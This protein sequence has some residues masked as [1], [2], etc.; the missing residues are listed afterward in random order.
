MNSLIIRVFR[1]INKRISMADVDGMQCMR[2]SDTDVL[3]YTL[4]ITSFPSVHITAVMSLFCS[5]SPVCAWYEGLSAHESM[6]TPFCLL[7]SFSS[8]NCI[9]RK[10]TIKG[11]ATCLVSIQWVSIHVAN[12]LG[13]KADR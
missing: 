5:F 12:G 9:R 7:F 2:A 13:S 3:T 11:D 1:S 8:S 4:G 10:T 6:H